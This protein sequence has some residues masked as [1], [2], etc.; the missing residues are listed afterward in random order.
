MA[1][2]D[3]NF[4]GFV[5]DN[6]RFGFF[7]I[8]NH[9]SYQRKGKWAN[10][11][12]ATGGNISNGVFQAN[13][14]FYHTFTNPG[15]FISNT[16]LNIEILMVA[17]GGGGS[18]SWGGGGAGGLFYHPSWTLQSGTYT[19]TVGLGGDGGT[20]AP[21]PATPG[22]NSTFV[23]PTFTATAVGGGAGNVGLGSGGSMGSV[24]GTPT[25][26]GTWSP[27]DHAKQP[28]QPQPGVPVG[29]QQYGFKCGNG[30]Y[31]SMGGGGGAGAAGPNATATGYTNGTNNPTPGGNGR[32]FPQFVGPIIGL[33]EL[34]PHAGYFAGGGGSGSGRDGW[35]N[36]AGTSQVGTGGLGGGGNGGAHNGSSLIDNA[37]AG[38]NFT[39]GGGGG[40]STFPNSVPGKPGGPGI[41][42][43]RYIA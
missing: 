39:G 4:I 33:P 6:A 30:A 24:F 41:V 38:A 23:G 14:Y 3:G 37:T 8:I 1:R 5:Q 7:D 34:N 16:P 28:T 11:S 15:S 20:I 35:V 36:N 31:Y 27:I 17:G 25:G 29:F 42:I 9:Y 2:Y 10:S 22:S 43:I 12:V 40:S 32:P 21:T 26:W 18:S 13:G 19:V